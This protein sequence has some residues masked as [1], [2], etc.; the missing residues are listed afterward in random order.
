MNECV[1]VSAQHPWNGSLNTQGLRSKV[2]VTRGECVHIFLDG[3]IPKFDCSEVVMDYVGAK[4]IKD[5]KIVL[6]DFEPMV[7]NPNFLRTGRKIPNFSLLPREAWANWLLCVTLQRVHGGGI[8]FSDTIG[9][10]VLINKKTKEW[11]VTEHV[12]ALD[13]PMKSRKVLIGED[14][15]V[16]AIE[17]K[18]AKGPSYAKGKILVVFHEGGGQWYPNRVGRRIANKHGF[19]A[20]YG[21][22]LLLGNESGYSYSVSQFEASHSPTWKIEIDFDFTD[23]KVTQ[24]Q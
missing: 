11:I 4:Q 17:K 14:R 6:K 1:V 21:I 19:V 15:V 22:G 23:W 20:V 5:F 2:G 18:V 8:T 16:A 3:A 9:D 10:G 24:V 13:V 12:S 7:K